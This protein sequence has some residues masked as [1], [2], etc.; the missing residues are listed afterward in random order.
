MKNQFQSLL[1]LT[2]PTI[3]ALSL[4][5]ARAQDSRFYVKAD[6]G[7]QLT[8]DTHLKEFF[9]EPV[10]SAQV[11]FDPGARVGF[12][13]GYQ[14]TDWFS[15]EGETGV[16]ANN[17]SSIGRGSVDATFANVPFLLN[18]RFQCP[19]KCRLTPYFGGGVGGAASVLDADHITFGGTRMHGSDSTAVFAY[20]AFA[21]L[22]Y[23]LNEQMAL[24]LEYHYFATSGADWEADRTFGTGTD[25]LK[26]AGTETHA[27]SIAF[28]FRF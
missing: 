27:V 18:A 25:H 16:M 19:G 28:T 13:G 17:I 7:G 4:T 11:K 26:F 8:L 21:G 12:V 2:V 3:A 15:A 20:Q 10:G 6:A 1:F 9:G 24:S 14:I 5:T 22:S 23:K